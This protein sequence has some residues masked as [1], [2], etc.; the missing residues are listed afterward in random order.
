MNAVEPNT[1]LAK[2][3]RTVAEYAQNSSGAK[4]TVALHILDHL[5]D[6]AFVTLDQVAKITNISAST[7]TRTVSA[8]GFR[9]YPEFQEEIR[10]IIKMRL[11][12]DR[13]SRL[14][15][16][17]ESSGSCATALRYDRENLAA[18]ESLNPVE[19]FEQAVS[20]L[21]KAKA[22]HLC[23]MQA[24]WATISIFGNYL[25]QIRP[26]VRV[27]NLAGMALSEQLLDI[28]PRDVFVLLTLPHYHSFAVGIA[29]DALELG[30][31][32]ISV[33]DNP[34]S[35]I[36][37]KSDVAFAVP[38]KSASFFNS[39]VAACSLFGALIT[40]VNFAIRKKAL[41]RLTRHEKMLRSWD[42]YL[43]PAAEK[44]NNHRNG[45]RS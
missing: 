13:R 3:M 24:S 21:T 12:P 11:S 22:V 32:L 36:G 25:S 16:P 5:E 1:E 8:M 30:C 35:P 41:E 28:A 31:S 23:G 26:G 37:L 45:N 10:E 40:E 14:L 15:P 2:V 42:L 4:R 29:E 33:T 44:Q 9:G 17:V 27:L 6:M 39:H 34:H 43:D 19:K 7:I 20:L 18:L 38:Y